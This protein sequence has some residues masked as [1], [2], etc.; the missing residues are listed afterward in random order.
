MSRID[1]AEQ[2]SLEGS[3][4]AA[5][6]ILRAQVVYSEGLM[7]FFIHE[8][9]KYYPYRMFDDSWQKAKSITP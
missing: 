3:G 7:D 1:T 2:M 6:S 8:L 5:Q 4:E 9:S